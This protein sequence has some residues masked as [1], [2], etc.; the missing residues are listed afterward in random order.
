MTAAYLGAPLVVQRNGLSNSLTV[1]PNVTR[2]G[3][4]AKL[5]A[6]A[7]LRRCLHVQFVRQG[8]GALHQDP[9]F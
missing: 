4:V 2:L 7:V 5:S 9:V 6:D 3:S 8:A 1:V